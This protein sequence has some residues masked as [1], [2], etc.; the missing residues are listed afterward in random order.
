MNIYR[1]KRSALAK[2]R[3]DLKKLG[4]GEPGRMLGAVTQD[5]ALLEVVDALIDCIDSLE[6]KKLDREV[7]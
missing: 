2:A 7:T 5:K 4:F 1:Q 3:S 6:N